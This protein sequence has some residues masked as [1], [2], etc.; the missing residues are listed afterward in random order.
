M[1]ILM[2]TKSI[3]ATFVTFNNVTSIPLLILYTNEGNVI[4]TMKL[5]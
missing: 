5:M 4:L 3:S 1:D 2:R